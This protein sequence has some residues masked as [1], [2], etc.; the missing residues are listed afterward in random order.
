M[1][2]QL[3]INGKATTVE[4]A[5]DEKLLATLRRCGYMSVKFGCGEGTCGTCTVLVD[6]RARLACL[7]FTAQMQGRAITT[8]EGLGTF[9]R[10]HALQ[11]AFVDEGAVQCGYC[12]PGM[13]LSAKALLDEIPKP[14]EEQIKRALDGNRCR[15]TGYVA[16]IKAVQRAGAEME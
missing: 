3:T 5:P 10:P 15:C 9:E 7:T 8:V 1:Q 16:I 2:M 14:S 6:G 4:A 12:T 11:R 13:I